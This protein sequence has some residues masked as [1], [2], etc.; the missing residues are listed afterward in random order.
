MNDNRT[1]KLF[2]IVL[3]IAII[4]ILA[5]SGLG[6]ADSR[7][8]KGVNEIRTGIDIRGGISAI[9]EPIYPNGSE[10]RNIKQDLESS[11]SIIEDRLDAQGVYDKSI[12]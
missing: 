1:F 3:I 12:N 5:F 6:P 10:G 11:Q 2:V 9:L 4:C 7:I 8:V